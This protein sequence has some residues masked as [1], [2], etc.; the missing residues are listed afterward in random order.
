H[1]GPHSSVGHTCFFDMQ[2]WASQG[3]NVLFTNPRASQGYGEAFATANIGDWGGGDWWEQE[4]ALDLAIE[5][6]GVDP[7]RL[8]VTGLSY[9]G[10]MTNWI[11]GQT[12]RY[13]V[14]VSE[15]GISNLVSFYTT[16]DIGPY[17]LE[18]EMEREVWSNLQW[19]MER[20]PISYV[21]KMQTPL[22]LLQ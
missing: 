21:P 4:M 15:N 6:G 16:S 12:D 3:W 1:G 14:A 9:G 20:S 22:L 11:I 19:Y 5:R 13:R 10:F 7:E 18:K 17:W 2:L 8:A